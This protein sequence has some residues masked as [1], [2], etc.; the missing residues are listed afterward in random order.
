MSNVRGALFHSQTQGK[1]ERWPQASKNRVL[2]ENYFLPG[3]LEARIEA[4]ASVAPPSAHQA[5]QQPALSREPEQR[6]ARRC[7]FRQD[8]SHHQTRDKT[9]SSLI[10]AVNCANVLTTGKKISA[11][12]G[13]TDEMLRPEFAPSNCRTNRLAGGQ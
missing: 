8:P 4:L 1:I 12:A 7:L 13:R 9:L 2:L 10:Q 3:G 5:L 11:N 6:D